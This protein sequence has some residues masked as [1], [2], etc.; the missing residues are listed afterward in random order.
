M[1]TA[2]EK[3]MF[4]LLLT[5][6]LIFG[7]IAGAYHPE[8]NFY[9]AASDDRTASDENNEEEYPVITDFRL[10]RQRDP[11]W[12]STPIGGSTLGSVGC[13]ITSIAM[14]AVASGAREIG[15]FDPCVFAKQLNEIGAF[16]SGGALARWASITKIIPEVA[17]TGGEKSFASSDQSGKAAEIKKN[18]ESGFYVICNVGGHWVYIDGVIGDDVYMA[19]PAKD[20]ILMFK[21]YN[22]SSIRYYQL[23]KGKNPYS[24]FTP[25]Y[26]VSDEGRTTAATTTKTVKT[27]TTAASPTT[28]V[29]K[30][31]TYVVQAVTQVVTAETAPSSSAPAA[32]TSTVKASPASTTTTS[33]TTAPET[34]TSTVT[35]LT[36]EYYCPSRSTVKVMGLVNDKECV[37]ATL[38]EGDIIDVTKTEGSKGTVSIDGSEGF[39]ELSELEFAGE[40][41]ELA[42]GDI[43]NDGTLDSYDLAIINEYIASLDM[44]PDGVSILRKC[45]VAAAD[46]NG[47]GAVDSGDVLLYLMR[48]CN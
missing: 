40:T 22:N 12:A 16:T 48:I 18:L 1:R 41:K 30:V 2:K 44:L 32:V 7:M 36:G 39:V 26:D 8:K 24:G 42:V 43:N 15:N 47:D 3:G 29:A 25:L 9:V 38:S 28:T 37:L 34:T 27:T 35:Y 6:V 11:R 13:Y 45:E 46:I 20:E 5:F 10:W 21:A 14:A 19:D 17:I 31:S 33:A 4:R 23:I